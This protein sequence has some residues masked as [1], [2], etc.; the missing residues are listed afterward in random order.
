LTADGILNVNKPRG[1]TSF[2]VVAFVRKQSG[3]KRVGHAGTLDPAAEGVLVVCLGHATRITEYL[4]NAR[5]SYVARIHLGMSTDTYDADGVVVRTADA[6]SVTREDIERALDSFKGEILQKP[7]LYSALKRQGTALY[8]HARAGRQVELEKRE[9]EVYRLELTEFSLPLMTLEVDCGRGFYVRS[10]AHDLGE[11]LGCGGHL[12]ALRRTAV[13][14]FR[15]E[16]SVDIEVLRQAF[17]EGNW[18][19]LLLPLDSVLLDWKAAILGEESEGRVRQGRALNVAEAAHLQE[20]AA[21]SEGTPCRA[22][23]LDGRL[24]ALLKYGGKSIWEP[25]KVLEGE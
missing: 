5:K 25:E 11:S 12:E 9:V 2:D 22:Y 24:I 7:P 13:G 19:E 6:S 8:K 21:A 18:Q 23:S 14:P 15:V 20:R 17:E 3:V 16:E 4:L 1:W 10:L